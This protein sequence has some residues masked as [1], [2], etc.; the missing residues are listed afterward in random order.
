MRML[1][2]SALLSLL[3]AAPAHATGRLVCRTAGSHPT[4]I[5]LVISHTVVPSIVSARLRDGG[6]EV[7]VRVAQ[8]WLE[9]NGLRLDL[10]D[11][12][13]VRH[14]LRMSVKRNGRAYDGTLQRAAER[15][16]VRCRDGG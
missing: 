9:P 15:R 7:P 2:T 5:D 6:R 10:V 8:S 16:W 14:E 4:E 12:N 11:S 1:I 13:A 3:A